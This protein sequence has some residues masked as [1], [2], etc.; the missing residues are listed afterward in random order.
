MI[1]KILDHIYVITHSWKIICA[2]QLLYE[3]KDFTFFTVN[4]WLNEDKEQYILHILQKHNCF[5][6]LVF[7]FK[8]CLTQ[9]TQI[10]ASVHQ[11]K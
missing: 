11:F 2:K 1:W 10:E 4:L 9:M 7:A 6:F 8:F 5:L 3:N